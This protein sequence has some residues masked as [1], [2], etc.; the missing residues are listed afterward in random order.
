MLKHHLSKY[1]FV[2]DL[3]YM[4]D[5]VRKSNTS[6]YIDSIIVGPNIC[7]VSVYHRISYDVDNN[8]SVIE[9]VMWKIFEATMVFMKLRHQCS[10]M[11]RSP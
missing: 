3:K 4:F 1:C 5:I 7:Q 2:L 10:L 9:Y 6:R 8:R 11:F